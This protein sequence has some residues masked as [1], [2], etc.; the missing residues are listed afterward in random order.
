MEEFRKCF[1]SYEVSNLGNCRRLTKRGEYIEIKGSTNNRGYKYFQVQREGKRV[2]KLIHQMV[3]LCFLG[4]RPEGCVV[5]HIDRNKLNNALENL[6]YT[7]YSNNS[8][9]SSWYRSDVGETD[10]KKRRNILQS[11]YYYQ[12]NGPPKMRKRGTGHLCKRSCSSW[13]AVFTH[14]K[15]KYEKSFSTREEGEVFLQEVREK[16][17]GLT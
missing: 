11:E 8:K 12:K 3:A 10:K 17:L 16:L 13:T 1:E 4:E 7:S 9:N 2:N 14:Q 5:D 15:K 6:R